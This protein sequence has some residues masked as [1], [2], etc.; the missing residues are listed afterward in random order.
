VFSIVTSLN[1]M[2][3][4]A[5]IPAYLASYEVFLRSGIRFIRKT[6]WVTQKFLSPYRK[7]W[8]YRAMFS[9]TTAE[10]EQSPPLVTVTP[11]DHTAWIVIAT[12]LGLV[13]STFF[14]LIRI[15][16]L[17]SRSTL[18]SWGNCSLAISMVCSC[19]FSF[20]TCSTLVLA[21]AQIRLCSTFSQH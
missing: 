20:H 21:D 6:S 7:P 5:W 14:T 13:T 16:V 3:L 8:F 15:V 17:W 18:K 4:K 1:I 10:W 11:E 12:V 19:L 2:L 9:N